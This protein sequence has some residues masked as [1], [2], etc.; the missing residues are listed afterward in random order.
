MIGTGKKITGAFCAA[1]RLK[2]LRSAQLRGRK[3]LDSEVASLV[4]AGGVCPV[5]AAPDIV[6]AG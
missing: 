2:Y 3:E 4:L 1:I 5:P 6:V